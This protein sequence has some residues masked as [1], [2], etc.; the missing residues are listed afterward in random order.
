MA[1]TLRAD[2]P[3][4]EVTFEHHAEIR[5]RGQVHSVRT[6][7]DAADTPATIRARFEDLYRARYGHADSK[8]PVEVVSLNLAGHGSMDR[9][10]LEALAPNRGTQGKPSVT[11]RS[12]YFAAAGTAVPTDVYKRA[13]L[14]AGFRAH[15]PALIEE[16]GSTTV[17]GPHDQFFIG[18]FG[19]IN[20]ELPVR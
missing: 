2:V 8:N 7:F 1:A 16:Y 12:V 19:E 18:E 11:Q 20:V 9:P 10:V 4:A 6:P 13:Q 3:D 5:Y 17:I 15:G 14:P